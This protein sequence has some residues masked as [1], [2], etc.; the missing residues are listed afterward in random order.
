M[1]QVYCPDCGALI[2]GKSRID[3]KNKLDKHYKNKHPRIYKR[4]L[5]K[6]TERAKKAGTGIGVGLDALA[7]FFG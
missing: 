5:I 3:L 6:S 2:Q 7:G 1:K 4:K